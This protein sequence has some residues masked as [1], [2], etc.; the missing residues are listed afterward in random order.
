MALL[1]PLEGVE[2]EVSTG[3]SPL[4]LSTLPKI[5]SPD[6]Q[7]SNLYLYTFLGL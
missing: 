4:S 1:A 6:N 7:M 2:V 3:I 5:R